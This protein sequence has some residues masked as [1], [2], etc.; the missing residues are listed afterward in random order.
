MFSCALFSN[1]D[2]L[3]DDEIEFDCSDSR[4]GAMDMLCHADTRPSVGTVNS[5]HN[6]GAILCCYVRKIWEELVV[7]QVEDG[8][9]EGGKAKEIWRVLDH[10]VPLNLAKGE[11]TLSIGKVDT[12]GK[13]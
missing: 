9:R 5:S 4:C 8:E 7:S 12:P 11:G 2:C 3:I 10:T 6:P 1:T 13:E